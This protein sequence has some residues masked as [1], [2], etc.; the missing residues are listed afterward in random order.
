MGRA[1]P[2]IQ[3]DT[4]SIYGVPIAP[5]AI[6]DPR[7][8]T[9]IFSRVD[10]AFSLERYAR[11][12]TI[13]MGGSVGYAFPMMTGSDMKRTLVPHTVTLAAAIGRAVRAARRN[14][15]DPVSAVLAAGSG[16]I[17]FDGKVVDV[18]RRN[19]G[20]FARGRIV[21]EGYQAYRGSTLEIDFQNEYL[22]ALVDGEVVAV[23]PDLICLVG[24]DTAEPVTT[25]LVRY[26]L[27]VVVIGM[28]AHER[29]KTAEALAVIGPAAFGYPD[30]AYAPMP[31]QYGINMSGLRS[32]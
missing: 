6:A 22:I 27:R 18:E 11:A 32:Q 24:A 8:N 12:V 9:V 23:V 28:P 5:A 20:G 29:L 3:M 30:V 10:D 16:V 4:F 13:Q 1:F 31:G 17:L 2:E 15:D 14:H 7:H 19:V 26:G 21:F 25:E